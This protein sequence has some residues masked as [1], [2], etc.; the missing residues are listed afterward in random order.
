VPLAEPR[1]AES[2]HGTVIAFSDVDWIE[3]KPTFYRYE[4]ELN[5]GV[6]AARGNTDTTDLHFDGRFEPSFG[7]DTLR[8]SAQYDRKEAERVRRRRKR[9]VAVKPPHFP[10][11]K[12]RKDT[13]RH[14]RGIGQQHR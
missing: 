11:L 4:A 3:K 2:I 10:P 1:H 6:Q 13:M 7:W 14:R 12:G 9:L 5:V 8:L